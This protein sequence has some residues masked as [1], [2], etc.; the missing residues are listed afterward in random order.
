M[1]AAL[2]GYTRFPHARQVFKIESIVRK[3]GKAEQRE[4]H[5]GVTS[6]GAG[7]AD[8]ERLLRV[9]RGHWGIENG[10]HW[11][12][13]MTFD[14]DRSRVR[15]GSGPQVMA[16]L[17]NLAITLLRLAGAKSIAVATRQCALRPSIAFRLIGAA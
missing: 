7:R 14:E 13:D 16:T 10:L 5:Y 1:S 17:R 12:R 15:T 11:V 9:N 6:L 3:P 8:W 4:V 2:E